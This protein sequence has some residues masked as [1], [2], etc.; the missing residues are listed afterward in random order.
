M[1]ILAGLVL[2]ACGGDDGE[3][4][5]D[6]TGDNGA[7]SETENGMADDDAADSDDTADEPDDGAG[8]GS[9]VDLSEVLLTADDLPD[10]AEVGPQSA[11][12]MTMVTSM[13]RLV[14]VQSEEASVEPS[15]CENASSSPLARD[16][17]ESAGVVAE[18]EEEELVWKELRG[19]VYA[20]ATADDVDQVA[21]F[22]EQCGEYTLNLP[23][24]G[25]ATAGS[26]EVTMVV[27][28][29][30]APEVDAEEVIA[31]EKA[32][33]GEIGQ[34]LEIVFMIDQ[35][36]GVV[37]AADSDST[38]FDMDELSQKA[39]ERLRSALA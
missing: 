10:E 14:E 29:T 6:A 37:L 27:S 26:A 25:E 24:G 18:V 39:L 1:A 11:V 20:N 28:E 22:I 33:E 32:E 9:D 21:E 36:Y 8:A 2:A 5:E 15:E 16:D 31:F 38:A 30:D 4:A 34:S 19:A 13:E 35:G 12:D 17:V 7:E 23:E 3:D